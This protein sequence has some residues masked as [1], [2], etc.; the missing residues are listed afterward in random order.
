LPTERW[1]KI[2][3]VTPARAWRRFVGSNGKKYAVYDDNTAKEQA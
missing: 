2:G 3:T 1:K